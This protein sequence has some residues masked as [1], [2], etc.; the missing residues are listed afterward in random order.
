MTGELSFRFTWLIWAGA[1]MVPWLAVFAARPQLRG[2]MLRSSAL[3][4][5]FGLTEPLFVPEY[6]NP[7]SLFELAQRT[8]FD[9]ESLV[10]CFAIGG[11]GV[12]AYRAVAP[13]ALHGIDHQ[14]RISPRHKWH[15]LALG[16]P[17][18]VF[19]AL[20][21]LPWN[22]IYPGIAAMFA[23]ALATVAC[24]PDLWRNSLVGGAVFLSLYTAFLF[25][26]EWIWPGYVAAVWNLAVLLPLRPWGLPIEE[27]LFA[28]GFGMYWSSVYEHLTWQQ[29]TRPHLHSLQLNSRT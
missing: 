6:W 16:T 21:G 18:V 20:V 2:P 1:F 22:P 14:A 11:L 4:S 28:F 9:I 15:L 10:F 3:T 19:V 8:G 12:A 7:P 29:H 5:L 25:G 23:G 13:S 24:R 26:L 27:F 17:F